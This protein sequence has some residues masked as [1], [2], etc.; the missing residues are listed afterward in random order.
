MEN[1]TREIDFL[2][3]QFESE[4]NSFKEV[5]VTKTATFK[6]LNRTERD[7]HKLHFML[8]SLFE[9]NDQNKMIVDSDKLYDITAKTIKTLLIVDEQFTEQDKTEFLND[10]GALFTFGIWLLKEH[11][12]PFFSRL[13]KK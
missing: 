3:R 10:S 4:S 6:E 9:S 8:I 11:I 13:M 1:F 7:Q 5:S 2:S 12:S